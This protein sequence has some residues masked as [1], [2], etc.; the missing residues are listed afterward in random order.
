MD[1][2]P[3]CGATLRT[4]FTCES[5]GEL[6]EPPTAPTPFAALGLVP[7]YDI[8]AALLRERLLALS[9][10]MHPDYF[11]GA[12]ERTRAL[13]L[14]NTAELN[15]SFSVL[16]DDFRRADHL[17]KTLGGP[18][19]AQERSMPAEFLQQV[20]EWNELIEEARETG[21]GGSG[22]LRELE[23]D[24]LERRTALMLEIGRAL[25]PLPAPGS[26]G[27]LRVRQ[28]LNAVRYLDRALRESSELALAQASGR[29]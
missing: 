12:D 3:K 28:L 2:C 5:C 9:R 15:A 11:A 29:R 27:L 18:G 7:A 16:S 24:L 21:R 6:L 10:A 20:L 8:D 19:E 13:A 17:V 23:H 1:R 25:T 22:P 4:P 14:R 26:A